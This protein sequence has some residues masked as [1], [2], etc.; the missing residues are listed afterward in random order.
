MKTSNKILISLF[1]LCL[2]WI[3]AAFFTA[4]SR[5]IAAIIDN[6]AYSENKISKDISAIEIQNFTHLVLI[7]EGT[8]VIE[9]A[10]NQSISARDLKNLKRF[11]RNDTLYIATK[12]EKYTL[13]VPQLKTIQ[14]KEEALIHIQNFTTDSIEIYCSEK[15]HVNITK[16]DFVFLKM[17]LN[18]EAKVHL[19]DLRGNNAVAQL[20]ILNHSELV[21]GK[22]KNTELILKK[23]MNA[24]VKSY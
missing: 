23:D 5:V 16:L 19:T 22:M 15:S 10:D 2:L 20:N 13:R 24:K 14:V 6:P 8:L 21:I 9:Q 7:G 3:F 12:K 18:D 4:K 17:I 11:I 1:A